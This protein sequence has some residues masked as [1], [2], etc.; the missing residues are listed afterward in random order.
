[1]K[2][3]RY[4]GSYHQQVESRHCFHYRNRQ[5]HQAAAR[6]AFE[7]GSHQTLPQMALQQSIARSNETARANQTTGAGKHVGSSDVHFMKMVS[8]SGT[9]KSTVSA[10][11]TSPLRPGQISVNGTLRAAT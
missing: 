5:S 7:C 1:M 8:L 3:H 2:H 6:W 9:S 11:V 10:G 4:C